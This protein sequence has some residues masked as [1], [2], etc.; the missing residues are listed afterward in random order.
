MNVIFAVIVV[1]S[2]LIFC[3]TSPSDFL[4]AMLDGGMNA[5]KC[6]LTLF[7]IYAVWLG[8]S[9]VAED[10]RITEKCARLLSPAC[11]KLFKTKDKTALEYITMNVSCNLLGIGGA[12]TP[13][14]VKAVNQLEKSGNTFAQNLLFIINATS[15][16]LIPTTV[17]ALRASAGSAAAYDITLPSLIATA[18]ST[19]LGAGI[20]IV[21][22]KFSAIKVNRRKKAKCDT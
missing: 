18:V 12:A 15:I 16:Q 1:V 9:A 11:T 17:I 10:C 8:L 7:C 5:A 21:F 19:F 6:C 2:A 4:P 22:N 20:Y 13:Y 14:G 3:F